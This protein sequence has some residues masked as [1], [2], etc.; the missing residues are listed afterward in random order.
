MENKYDF[1]VEIKEIYTCDKLTDGF[2]NTPIPNRKAVVRLDTGT[3]VGLTSNR[4]QLVEHKEVIRIFDGISAM[5]RDKV[6]ICQ[7]GAIMF[8]DYKMNS[9]RDT[10][11]QIAVGDVVDFKIRVFNSY[12][13]MMGIGFEIFA[14]R[15]VC[16][17]GLMIPKSVSR[18]SYKH[19]LGNEAN[20]LK[21]I[22]ENTYAN[23]LDVTNQWLNWTRERALPASINS[24]FTSVGDRL[25]QKDFERLVQA[26][27]ASKS[28]WE[29]FNVMT[30]YTTH[31]LHTRREDMK[32][33]KQRDKEQ[34][35]LGNFYKT[36]G[37]G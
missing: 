20:R 22:V 5:H 18:L 23:S 27:H 21:D 33:I 26:S 16:T 37:R 36:F 4:Y 15:L 7:G 1:P 9:G 11:R 24:Y 13:M 31:E 25:G 28:V 12:N 3:V 8:A 32:L 17:N 35:L 30:Q 19:L 14:I 34:D 6:E 2:L 29:M 10:T